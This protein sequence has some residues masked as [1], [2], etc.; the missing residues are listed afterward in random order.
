MDSHK[1]V[2]LIWQKHKNG[3]KNRL[4]NKWCW[5]NWTSISKKKNHLPKRQMNRIYVLAVILYCT[6]IKDTETGLRVCNI[7]LYYVL[8][9]HVNKKFNLKMLKKGDKAL[10]IIPMMSLFVQIKLIL[11]GKKKKEKEKK[12]KIFSPSLT[13]LFLVVKWSFVEIFSFVVPN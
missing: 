10:E 3:A 8:Q 6:C 13:Y 9:L 7:S 12:L 11:W 1:Q 2:Q 5:I 4:F